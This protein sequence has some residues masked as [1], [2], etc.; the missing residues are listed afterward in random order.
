MLS[1]VKFHDG[2]NMRGYLELDYCTYPAA[3]GVGAVPKLVYLLLLVLLLLLLQLLLLAIKF[4][5]FKSLT[6]N[7][8]TKLFFGCGEQVGKGMGSRPRE[9]HALAWTFFVKLPLSYSRS[10]TVEPLHFVLDTSAQR[11]QGGLALCVLI[12]KCSMRRH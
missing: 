4:S 1:P 12:G 7:F 11:I 3:T 2:G 10:P 5:A 9:S 6:A 8:G